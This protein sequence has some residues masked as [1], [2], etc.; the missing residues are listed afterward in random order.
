MVKPDD[1]NAPEIADVS[2][3]VQVIAAI[4]KE[5]TALPFI[6][7]GFDPR[8]TQRPGVASG[9][10]EIEID[11]RLVTGGVEVKN[12]DLLVNVDSG[13]VWRVMKTRSDEMGRIFAIVN[14]VG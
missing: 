9:H 10:P 2:R 14:L 4:Y 13:K 1:V 12:P 7:N 6:P 11:P 8:S 5:P 3:P